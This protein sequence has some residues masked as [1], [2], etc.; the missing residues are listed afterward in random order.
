MKRRSPDLR[1]GDRVTVRGLPEILATL[2]DDGA[3]E[4][5]P[6]LP[7]MAGYCGRT[8]TVRRRV[9]KL[10]QEGV[11]SSM[12]RLR[13]VVLLEEAICDGRAHGDCRRACFPL[14]KTAWLA[15]PGLPAPGRPAASPGPAS[16]PSRGG[17]QVTELMRATTP[18]PLWNPVRHLLDIRAR[19]YSP[20]E[21]AAYVLGAWQRKIQARLSGRGRAVAAPAGAPLLPDLGLRPG[22]IVEVRSAAE[23]WA[24]LDAEGRFRGL[25]FMPG[26]WAHCGRR[27]RVLHPVDRMMS[28]KTGELRTLTRTVI[29]EGVTCDGKAH[30]GC[31]RG[32]LVFWKDAWLRRASGG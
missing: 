29:L 15:G 6:F 1:P 13:D 21:L 24:T 17:C 14:W 11:G 9:E 31:Q 8:L 27:L 19:T 2:D 18:L 30:G 32:C 10:I 28:E 26:M 5:L 12:R 4:G 23:I 25:Y 3:L 22:D 16:L 7:E 20:R